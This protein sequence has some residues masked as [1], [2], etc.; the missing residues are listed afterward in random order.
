MT[1]RISGGAVSFTRR[2]PTEPYAHK[3]ATI[4]FTIAAD[5]GGDAQ[6]SVQ[7]AGDL[8]FAHVH[9]LLGVI[10]PTL[11]GHKDVLSSIVAQAEAMTGRVD[12][13][14]ASAKEAGTVKPPKATKPPTPPKAADPAG[15]DEP[16]SEAAEDKAAKAHDAAA[17][18]EDEFTGT[19]KEV[20]DTDLTTACGQAKQRLGGPVEPIKKLI[21]RYTPQDGKHYMLIDIPQDKRAAFLLE[22]KALKKE[23]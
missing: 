2:L 7:Q 13:A 16:G 12:L 17:M 3:E 1:S 21:G 4:S 18:E 6:A 22:L 19:P 9:R 8:A 23:D 20:T 15:F 10:A 14:V 5:D 11:A